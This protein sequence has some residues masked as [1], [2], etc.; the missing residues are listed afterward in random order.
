MNFLS[1]VF[2]IQSAGAMLE[3]SFL[4]FG[5]I[6]QTIILSAIVY[7]LKFCFRWNRTREILDVLDPLDFSIICSR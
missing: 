2:V 3:K 1:L 6:N 7:F 4:F 5:T